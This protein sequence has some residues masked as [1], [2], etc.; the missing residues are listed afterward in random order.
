VFRM[1]RMDE[2]S[3]TSPS[4]PYPPLP[5]FCCPL[6]IIYAASV[7]G[8]NAVALVRSPCIALSRPY[9][10]V[11]ATDLSKRHTGAIVGIG[12]RLF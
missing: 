8:I 6:Q 5:L 3:A 10:S 11:D 7:P 4:Y 9:S 1:N 2:M 12:Q